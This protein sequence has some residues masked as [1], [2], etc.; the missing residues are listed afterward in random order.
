MNQQSMHNINLYL[1]NYD[2]FHISQRVFP[3]INKD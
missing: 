1:K 2:F 3:K